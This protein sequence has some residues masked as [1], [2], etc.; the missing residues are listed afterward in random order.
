ML[1][2]PAAV[3]AAAS[4]V[5]PGLRLLALTRLASV[6]DWRYESAISPWLS[7]SPYSAVVA[8]SSAGSASSAGASSFT[9]ER[10]FRIVS[11]AAA[12]M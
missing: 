10:P 8:V 3:I 5:N 6:R 9:R 4:V 11:G 7:N 2:D 1:V 12:S